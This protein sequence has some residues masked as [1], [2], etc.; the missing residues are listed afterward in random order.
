M[1]RI[2]LFAVAVGF[3]VAGCTGD[4]PD[5][6]EEQ[7]R[8]IAE[9]LGDGWDA[10]VVDDARDGSFVLARP[11][12]AAV[13][14]VGAPIDEVGG[15]TEDTAWGGFWLPALGSATA[16][17]NIRAVVADA[18]TLPGTVVSWQVNVNRSDPGLELGLEELTDELRDRFTAQ[19]LEVRE[20]QVTSWNDRDIALVAFTVPAE[21]F[22]G[23]ERYVRQWF[24][25]ESSPAAMWSFSCDAPADPQA[26][27]ELCRTGLD[28]FRVPRPATGSDA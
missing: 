4:A 18:D 26:S 17:S 7:S 28:G 14:T 24:I 3:A 9:E 23:E 8:A 16:D 20:S 13:W 22:G 21:V 2:A 12:H 15:V 6:P 27:A 25:P 19:G 11:S 5:T 10:E 1:R